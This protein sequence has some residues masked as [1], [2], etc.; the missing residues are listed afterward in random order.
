LT[1]LGGEILPGTPGEFAAYIKAQ[2]PKF[3]KTIK[4][5]NIRIE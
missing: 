4:S 1:G 2:T 3:A 5:A